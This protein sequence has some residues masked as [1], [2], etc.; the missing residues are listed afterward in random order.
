[1]CDNDPTIARLLD[2]VRLL[3]LDADE[4]GHPILSASLLQISRAARLPQRVTRALVNTGACMLDTVEA[5]ERDKR[6][7]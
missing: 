2:R 5:S 4:Q 6:G 1:M 7:V 3:A